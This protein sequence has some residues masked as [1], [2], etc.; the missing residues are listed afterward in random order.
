MIQ[1]KYYSRMYN[2]AIDFNFLVFCSFIRESILHL[3]EVR[4]SHNY[5][6]DDYACIISVQFGQNDYINTLPGPLQFCR[7]PHLDLRVRKD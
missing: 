6:L 1:A 5:F 7:V 3:P 2:V 4:V